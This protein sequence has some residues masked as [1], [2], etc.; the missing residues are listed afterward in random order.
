MGELI[1]RLGEYLIA[2]EEVRLS[3]PHLSREKPKYTLRPKKNERQKNGTS[4][5]YLHSEA[6]CIF[7]V[8]TKGLKRAS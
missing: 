1:C 4:K 5:I 8:N 3:E 6:R 2:K 7:I